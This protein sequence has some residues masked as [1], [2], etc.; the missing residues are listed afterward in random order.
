MK[1]FLLVPFTLCLLALL[2]SCAKADT[3][4]PTAPDRAQSTAKQTSAAERAEAYP[5]LQEPIGAPS[6]SWLTDEY[7]Y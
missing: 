7:L 3:T 6:Y 4:Q 2:G 1:K 5:Y